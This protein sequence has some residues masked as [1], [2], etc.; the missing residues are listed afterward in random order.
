MI[1]HGYSVFPIGLVPLEWCG[2]ETESNLALEIRHTKEDHHFRGHETLLP[3]HLAC[4]QFV[5]LHVRE[6]EKDKSY[7]TLSA[8]SL[9]GDRM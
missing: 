6:E 1:Q 9:M 3:P 2:N 7:L 5:N 8:L 4:S